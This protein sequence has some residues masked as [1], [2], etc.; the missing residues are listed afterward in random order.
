MNIGGLRRKLKSVHVR[1]KGP[2]LKQEHKEHSLIAVVGRARPHIIVW[3]VFHVERLHLQ[4][5]SNGN[6]NGAGELSAAGPTTLKHTHTCYIEQHGD[7]HLLVAAVPFSLRCN[8]WGCIEGRGWCVVVVAVVVCVLSH[9]AHFP[10][11][12]YS[13]VLSCLAMSSA[14]PHG[15][16]KVVVVHMCISFR[17][18]GRRTGE[19]APTSYSGS[20]CVVA[21]LRMRS[22][23]Y[24]RHSSTR[25]RGGQGDG[26]LDSLAGTA[27]EEGSVY[28]RVNGRHYSGRLQKKQSYIR[29]VVEVG[30][31][32]YEHAI[33]SVRKLDGDPV[34]VVAAPSRKG[35]QRE[36]V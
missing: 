8:V 22:S 3:A 29:K 31:V 36:T 11:Q 18:R 1:G 33:H 24:S 7:G 28:G 19:Y 35:R 32:A 15:P 26:G 23:L 16:E 27:G 25:W 17:K 4:Q 14:C 13:H 2:A 5:N 34:G 6:G 20:T 10:P 30:V 9:I 21:S 12:I